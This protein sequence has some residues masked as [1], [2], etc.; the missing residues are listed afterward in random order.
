MVNSHPTPK[1]APLTGGEQM[2][3]PLNQYLF[4]VKTHVGNHKCVVPA[5]PY[6]IVA[7]VLSPVMMRRKS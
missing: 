4:V 1:Y 7:N 3:E 2:T 5:I 6:V